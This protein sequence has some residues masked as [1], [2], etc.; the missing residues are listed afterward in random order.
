MPGKTGDTKINQSCTH[1][2][3]VNFSQ[4]FTGICL[5]SD[6]YENFFICFEQL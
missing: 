3:V 4:L 5:V 1:C 6:H 2:S